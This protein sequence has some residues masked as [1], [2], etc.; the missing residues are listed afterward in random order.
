MLLLKRCYST[1]NRIYRSKLFIPIQKDQKLQSDQI[2]SQLLMQKGGMIR[3]ASVGIYMN[4]P[5]GYR[6]LEN[7]SRVIDQEMQA[8][9]GQKLSMPVLLSKQLWDKTGRW[10]SSGDDL[11]KLK[12]RKEDEYCL[13]PTHEEIFTDLIAQET[14]A[15]SIFPLKLYQIGEK[16]R[17]EIRPRFGLLRGKEFLMKDMYSFDLTVEDASKTYYQ[18]KDAYHR[19][20]NR[21]E[22]NYAC[23]EADSGNI[24]GSLSHEFQ[25][26]SQV[27]EDTLMNCN[28]CG[29]HSNIEKAKSTSPRVSTQ[30]KEIY[31]T[32]FKITTNENHQFLLIALVNKKDEVN[33]FSFKQALPGISIKSCDQLTNI[34][35]LPIISGG[36]IKVLKDDSIKISNEDIL[37]ILNTKYSTMMNSIKS[38]VP[39]LEGLIRCSQVGD[40]CQQETCK[41]HQHPIT[42]GKGIEVGH[43]FYLGTKYSQPLNANIKNEK[44]DLVPLEMGCYGIGVSRLLATVI[45][46]LSDDQGYKWPREIAPYQLIILPKYYNQESLPNLQLAEQIS[47]ELVKAHPN[48]VNQIVIDDRQINLGQKMKEASFLG[49]PMTLIIGDEKPNKARFELEFRSDSKKKLEL[50]QNDLINYFK[51]QIK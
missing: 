38:T 18:V 39:V 13:A 49:F 36:D 23:V 35:S 12:D 8:I 50:N 31:S 29:Y 21:L 34:N 2:K 4:L 6:V 40:F 27:G 42:S 15:N 11:I 5:F 16:F 37:D 20:F 30:V 25:V 7:I 28:A 33:Q 17:D 45:E 41:G 51:N 26:L 48:L 24:G 46:T 1:S 22:L 19:I 44:G 9:G 32:F 14:M 10:E 3:K 47:D 43:I